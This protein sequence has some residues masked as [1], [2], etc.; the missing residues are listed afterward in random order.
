MKGL[1]AIGVLL[2]SV[3]C[4]PGPSEPVAVPSAEIPFRVSRKVEPIRPPERNVT[5]TLAMV[6]HGKLVLVT[7]EL[8]VRLGNAESALRALI[9]GPTE[10]ERE[11]DIATEI[12]EDTLLLSVTVVDHVADVNLSREFQTPAPSG[13]ILLRVAQVVRTA[14]ALKGVT[15]IR[16]SIDGE[17]VSV[18]TDTGRSVDRPV[19]PLDY[20][21][22]VAKPAS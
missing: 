16:F 9:E 10:R 1:F 14:T 13:S 12:P 4:A 19:S 15:A 7:R 20:A 5:L 17:P 2:A 6:R 21:S 8:S 3:S 11:R 22:V 18:V